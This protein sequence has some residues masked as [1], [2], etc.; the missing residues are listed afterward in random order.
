LLHRN[1][2]F[3]RVHNKFSGILQSTSMNCANLVR[4]SRFTRLSWSLNFLCRQQHPKCEWPIHLVCQACSFKLCP[5][6]SSTDRNLTKTALQNQTVTIHN[7]GFGGLEVAWWPLVPKYTGSHPAEAV[8]FF[9]AKK[10]LSTPSFG[11]EVQPSVPC[12]SFMACKR[13]LSVKCKSGFR[14]NSRTFLAHCSTFRRRVLSRGDTRGEA[15]WQKLER[16]TKIAQ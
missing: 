16:L 15:W 7:S 12:R 9:R 14:Q 4:R 10:I 1:G 8:G 11:G 13:S 3:V 6:S 2:K 5:S